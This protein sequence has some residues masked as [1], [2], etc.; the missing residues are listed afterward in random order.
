[1]HWL[2]Y[3]A[4]GFT[5][6]L[7]AREARSR[8]MRPVL[9]GR[10]EAEVRPLAETLGLAWRVFSLDDELALRSAIEDYR[11][12]VHCAG[13]FSATAEPMIRACLAA[14]VYYL[15][16]TGEIQVFEFAHS[17]AAEARRADVVLLPGVGFDVVPS[18]CLAASLVEALPAATELRLAFEA[19]GG[20][21]P[22]TAK[23]SVEGLARGG[24][25]RRDGQLTPVPLA[26][27]DRKIPFAHGERTAVTI[28][29][30]DVFT[31]Y[32]STGIPDIEVYMSVPPA[33]V[34]RLRRLRWAQPLLRPAAVQSFLQKRIEGR[35][36]GPGDEARE[37]SYCELWGEVRSADG[38]TASATMTTPNGYDVTVSAAL[39]IA[40]H[41]LE[42]TVEGGYY[43]P[44]LLMGSAYAASLPGV[45][46]RRVS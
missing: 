38:R 9:A 5:G 33:T 23:T 37:R 13:P 11:L 1:M 16:I 36:H 15:D 14:G 22:G 39:G 21:S 6:R 17:L 44:S 32:V 4:N 40:A 25:V 42:T 43:T 3:G 20:P 2:I 28:P 31:A 24:C 46:F 45:R 41:L 29:W 18:D 26:W 34:R 19:S 27:K 12:V 8:G 10:N 35:V 30:G 7:M